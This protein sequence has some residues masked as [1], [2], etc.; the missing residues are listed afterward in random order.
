MYDNY[1]RGFTYQQFAPEFKAEFFNPGDWAELF[2]NAGM[3]YVVLTSKHHEGF[4]LFPSNQS[5][6][7]NSVDVGPHRDLVGDLARA[8]RKKNLEFGVYHSLYEWFNPLY[9]NDRDKKFTSRNYVENKLRPDI[10]QLITQYKPSVFWSDGDW[11]AHDSYWNST[12]ILAWLYNDSP[13]KDR[14]VVNDRWGIGTYGKHGD[15]YNIADRFNPGK[16][17]KHKWEN[18]FT[19]DTVSWGYRRNILIYDIL[20]TEKIIENV[21]ST[22]S[23]GG[24]ALINVGP[25][26]EGTIDPIF[27]ER[28]LALGAWLDINGEAIY[29]TSPWFHQ[30]DTANGKVWYTCTNIKYDVLNPISTPEDNESVSNI[31]AIILKWPDT[32]ILVLKDITS[33]LLSGNYA[34]EMLGQGSAALKVKIAQGKSFISLPD[35]ASVRSK[36]AWA[37][38]INLI[39]RN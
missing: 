13:V 26:K 23:C 10:E 20:S 37:L 30:N 33:I 31:Y 38:K 34:V 18:A 28:L 14:V 5:F 27:Q 35:K 36:H 39:N 22:V 17:L 1:P 4:T 29:N 2:K 19:V 16:L 25:T 12:D 24:N 3:K 32:N 11:E 7:W 8:I 15:F 6:S 9:L 21:V